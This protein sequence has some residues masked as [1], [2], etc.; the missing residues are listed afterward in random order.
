MTKNRKKTPGKVLGHPAS[1]RLAQEFLEAAVALQAEKG[2]STVAKTF[3][4]GWRMQGGVHL[5]TN[6]E[7]KAIQKAL[8]ETIVRQLGHTGLGYQEIDS[9]LWRHVSSVVRNAGRDHVK[10]DMKETVSIV[11][12]EID[13]G[14]TAKQTIFFENPLLREFPANVALSVGPVKIIDSASFRTEI[15]PLDAGFVDWAEWATPFMWSVR[16]TCARSKARDQAAWFI[17]IACGFFAACSTERMPFDIFRLGWQMY[18]PTEATDPIRR[19]LAILEGRLLDNSVM[20]HYQLVLGESFVRS[21]NAS[22]IQERAAMLFGPES[23]TVGAHLGVA[24][25]WMA[26]G[27]QA[28]KLENRLLFFST[29]LETILVPGREGVTDQLARHGASILTENIEGRVEYANLLRNLYVSRSSLVHEG[30]RALHD[31]DVNSLEF[32][33][34][35]ILHEIWEKAN[36]SMQFSVFGTLLK[37]SAFGSPVQWQE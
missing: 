8:T 6:D 31:I 23:Q 4:A 29:A 2:K 10:S 32:L 16:T 20:N 21:L 13:D 30:D 1:R 24:M 17:D 33:T 22:D 11:L 9:V 7:L 25:G 26:R 27:L 19:E 3:R 34:L 37:N 35:L 12:N 15:A 5:S 14:S 36:L 28:A 18:H